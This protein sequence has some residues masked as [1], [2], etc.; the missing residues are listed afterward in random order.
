VN[1][2]V[3]LYFASKKRETAKLH[4]IPPPDKGYGVVIV[5]LKDGDVV[6]LESTWG[7]SV[8]NLERIFDWPKSIVRKYEFSDTPAKIFIPNEELIR[9]IVF[10]DL[11]KLEGLGRRVPSREEVEVLLRMP[12]GIPKTLDPEG[13]KKIKS[14]LPPSTFFLQVGNYA[15]SVILGKLVLAFSYEGD[16]REIDIKDFPESEAKMVPVDPLIALS[17]NLP[18]FVTPYEKVGKDGIEEI[19]RISKKGT[20]IWLGIFYTKVGVFIPA[21]GYKGVFLGIVAKI[22]GEIKV[23]GEDFLENLSQLGDFSVRIYEYDPYMHS[24]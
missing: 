4:F 6:G 17:I 9:K 13:V 14:S 19:R 12:V 1:P 7:S 3:V 23:F 22:R 5:Y 24:P 20:N 2:S 18:F 16:V 21:F 15:I 11:K 10:S 8:E